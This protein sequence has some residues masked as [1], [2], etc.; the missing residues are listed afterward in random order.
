MKK[1]FKPIIK[2]DIKKNSIN[3][4]NDEIIEDCLFENEE[5][6]IDIK[7]VEFNGCVFKNVSFNKYPIANTDFIDCA[8]ESC[9]LSNIDIKEKLFLRCSFKN[10]SLVGASIIESSLKQNTFLEC[11]LKYTNIS[12]FI[13]DVSFDNCLMNDTR[14]FQNELNNVMFNNCDLTNAE[15]YNTSLKN[16]DLS[17]CKID[18]INADIGSIKGVTTDMIGVIHLARIFGVNVKL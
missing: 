10:C 18:G 13:K 16:I 1:S 12:C 14:L 8:F 17:T 4:I 6:A 11:N 5:C 7:N 15:V 9:D 3:S 2:D